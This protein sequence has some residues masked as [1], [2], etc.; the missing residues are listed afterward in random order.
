MNYLAICI[1]NYNRLDK[2]KR[3]IEVSAKQIIQSSLEAKVE[4]CISDDHSPEDP[5]EAI[6]ILKKQYP[7]VAIHYERNEK[8]RG[9][10]YNFLQSVMIA[11]SEYCWIVGND[12]L[13]VENAIEE[14]VMH[15]KGNGNSTDILVTPFDVY[16]EQENK[17]NSIYPL[18]ELMD[19]TKVFDTTIRDAYTNLLFSIN[20]NSGM[21]G[22]LSNVVFKRENWVRYYERF[23]DKL[24]TIFIQIY[25]NIQ[26][27]EDGAVYE[28]WQQKIIKNYADDEINDTA[29]RMGKVLIGLEG[30]IEYFFKGD[31]AQRLRKI[32]VDDYISGKIW[33]LPRE[34]EIKKAAMLIDS[35]KNKLYHR[36]FIEPG[37]RDEFF[38]G[39]EVVVFG[40][41][42]FGKQAMDELE[43]R[44]VRIIA[45]VDSDSTKAGNLFGKYKIQ[46]VD[47]LDKICRGIQP[48]IVIAN[49][50][51]LVEM[52]EQ[53]EKKGMNNIAIIT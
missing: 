41:G 38:A 51:Y 10:D 4:I 50:K 53:I 3:L 24:D 13:P 5:T 8:N 26:T 30:V 48:V 36:F 33:S 15:L 21:F 19:N 27:L 43:T 39:K 11:D 52:V 7:Q 23:Q 37:Q 25:M 6:G 47:E 44:G 2:L 12:D 31:I 14:I 34:H 32:V 17:R 49:H 9:M 35:E 22:F 16:D 46:L 42:K 40:A 1:P 18:G 28:Y 20:H 45:I 29:D